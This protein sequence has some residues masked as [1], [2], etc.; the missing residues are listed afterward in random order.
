[1]I[2]VKKIMKDT[3]KKISNKIAN[4]TRIRNGLAVFSEKKKIKSLITKVSNSLINEFTTD[5]D[6]RYNMIVNFKKDFNQS[7]LNK[8]QI[9]KNKVY[10]EIVSKI[11]KNNG[12]EPEYVRANMDKGVVRLMYKNNPEKQNEI[13]NYFPAG[14]TGWSD[15]LIKKINA[16]K[17]KFNASQYTKTKNKF[18]LE[19][20]VPAL[21]F[22]EINNMMNYQSVRYKNF[23]PVED[24]GYCLWVFMLT[25]YKQNA[26]YKIFDFLHDNM[27][28]GISNH[29]LLELF[30][31]NYPEYIH[32]KETD[33]NIIDVLNESKIK[34]GSI[35]IKG[36]LNGYFLHALLYRKIGQKKYIQS[37]NEENVRE[38]RNMRSQAAILDTHGLIKK[39][40]ENKIKNMNKKEQLN[41][42]INLDA[43][44]NSDSIIDKNFKDLLAEGK[45]YNHKKQWDEF[46][47]RYDIVMDAKL[48][49]EQSKTRLKIARLERGK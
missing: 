46:Y 34:D 37:F 14:M 7:Y 39:S 49:T 40:V 31:N 44:I 23:E 6:I 8:N 47:K 21:A 10:D 13:S 17:N 11:S 36:N 27:N 38:L 9:Q 29:K 18:I 35:I 33:D 2:V 48:H 20:W 25:L 19:Y 30:Q 41:Y 15:E 42:L 16:E 26:K 4:T 1:M 24:R 43:Q 28:K 3:S 5:V 12:V 32:V 45:K 22:A